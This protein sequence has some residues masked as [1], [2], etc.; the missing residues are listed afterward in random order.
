MSDN[1][2][3]DENRVKTIQGVSTVDGITPVN[4]AVNPVDGALLLET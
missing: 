3:H 1:A 2:E 4:I